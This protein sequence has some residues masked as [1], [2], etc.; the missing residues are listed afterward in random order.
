VSETLFE[1]AHRAQ[2]RATELR[3]RSAKVLA[4][5]EETVHR[6][7]NGP[8]AGRLR[9]LTEEVSGLRQAIASRAVIE[10]AKGVLMARTGVDPD[11]AFDLLRTQSQHEN[12]KLREVAHDLVAQQRRVDRA[13]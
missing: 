5:A 13:G 1:A 9:H 12:R 3:D 4:E 8:L 2:L 6:A 7:R 11:A 10:Q